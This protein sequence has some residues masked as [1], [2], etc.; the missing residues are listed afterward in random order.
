MATYLIKMGEVFRGQIEEE[1]K[2]MGARHVRGRYMDGS[3][4]WA[5][6]AIFPKRTRQRDVTQMLWAIWPSAWVSVKKPT[7]AEI[8]EFTSAWY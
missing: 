7:T 4:T 5:V 3:T 6:I 8:N 2:R 1:V